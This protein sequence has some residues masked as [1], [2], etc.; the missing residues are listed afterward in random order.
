[1]IYSKQGL[2]HKSLGI[3]ENIIGENFIKE[4]NEEKISTIDDFKKA[5][6]GKEDSIQIEFDFE[7]HRIG[8]N[9]I[10]SEAENITGYTQ[11]IELLNQSAK[12]LKHASYI[13]VKDI[14]LNDN[15]F[16]AFVDNFFNDQP[17]ILKEDGG[18]DYEGRLA[19]IRVINVETCE[20]VLVNSEGYTYP[21][22]TAIEE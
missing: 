14:N 7:K 1:M 13:V 21:R 17:W 15:Q 3:T 6:D 22:Y 18:V 2:I 8:F 4:L 11:F 19:C 5:I 12:E 20:K 9:F 16:K 10:K